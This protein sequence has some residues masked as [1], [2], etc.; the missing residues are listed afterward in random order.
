MVF[1]RY[2][3][4]NSSQAT[5]CFARCT[6]QLFLTKLRQ[7]NGGTDRLYVELRKVCGDGLGEMPTSI[8]MPLLQPYRYGTLTLPNGYAF[9]GLVLFPATNYAK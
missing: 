5:G 2:F 1:E 7:E 9:C 8:S 4:G 6:E 3:F